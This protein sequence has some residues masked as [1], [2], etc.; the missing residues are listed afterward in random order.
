MNA[1]V[2]KLNSFA[3][4]A[5]GGVILLTLALNVPVVAAQSAT[6]STTPTTNWHPPVAAW[7][8]VGLGPG[9]T[10][11]APGG[12]VAGVVRANVS[13]GPW[14][15]MY[16][17]NDVGPF[18]S[19]GSGVRDAGILAGMRTGGHRLFG[20]AALG[21][22]RANSYHQSDNSSYPDVA[23]SVGALAYDFALHANAYVAGLALSFYGDIGPS[24]TTYSAFTLSLELG[25]FGR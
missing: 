21:Y 12:G 17:A 16:R 9:R 25:W 15:L 5:R 4:I 23:P 3:R 10:Q 13:V 14:L 7:G 2:V 1:R 6:D 22:A 24:H 19:A 20:S 11:E 18:I 8:S